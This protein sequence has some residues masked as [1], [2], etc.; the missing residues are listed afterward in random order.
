MPP[1]EIFDTYFFHVIDVN[2]FY[3]IGAVA[4]A[5]VRLPVEAEF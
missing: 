4:A 2:S 5:V 3:V 1:C